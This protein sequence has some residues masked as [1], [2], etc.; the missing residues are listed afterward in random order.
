[1]VDDQG[2]EHAVE[3]SGVP[4]DI[5]KML[6]CPRCRGELT[7]LDEA[8]ACA[9]CVVRWPVVAGVPWLIPEKEKRWRDTP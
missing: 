1:M 8:L 6:V 5:L 3:R 7:E 2:A 9:A 4:P